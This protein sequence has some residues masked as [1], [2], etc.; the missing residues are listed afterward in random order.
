MAHKIPTVIS[1]NFSDGT[2]EKRKKMHTGSSTF[3][4]AF[5]QI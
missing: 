2:V 5:S 1:V 4:L 3:N